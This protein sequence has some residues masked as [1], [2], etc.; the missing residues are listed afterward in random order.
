MCVMKVVLTVKT[1][2]RKS[3]KVLSSRGFYKIRESVSW[4]VTGMSDWWQ[5][6]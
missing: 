4:I 5:V 3:S 1:A 2:G 6:T